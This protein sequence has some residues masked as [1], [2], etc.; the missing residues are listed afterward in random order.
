MTIITPDSNIVYANTPVI[1]ASQ[2]PAQIASVDAY[3]TR[4]PAD[5]CGASVCINFVP[6]PGVGISRYAIYRSIVGFIADIP[7]LSTVDGKTLQ[8]SINLGPTQEVVFNSFTPVVDRIN[9]VIDGGSAVV[10]L[11]GPSKLIFRVNGGSSPGVV[12]ILGGTALGDLGLTA[13]TISYQS[14][15][16]L[17][18]YVDAQPNDDVNGVEFCDLDGTIYDSYRVATVDLNNEISVKTNYVTPQEATGK[19]CCIYGIVTDPSGVRMPDTKV[20]AKILQYP[21]SVASPSYINEDEV[22]VFTNSQG[23]FEICVLQNALIELAIPDAYY[24]RTIRVPEVVQVSI[25]DLEVD[26]D[27]RLPLEGY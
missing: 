5:E 23:R 19:I 16:H 11:E 22:E 4:N 18:S 20:S 3:Y 10:S 9:A 24:M 2:V 27:Y 6:L 26:R 17:L 14:E 1:P 12:E 8:L 25:T 7:S 21:Q 15:D 13:R